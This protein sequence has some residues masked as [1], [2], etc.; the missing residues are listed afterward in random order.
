[1]AEIRINFKDLPN[2]G[3][4]EKDFVETTKIFSEAMKFSNIKL[5]KYTKSNIIFPQRFTQEERENVCKNQ[6]FYKTL[7]G[8]NVE[9]DE[10]EEK[11]IISIPITFQL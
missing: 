1:M 10:N 2:S 6:D 11:E 9:N 7:Y 3:D 8:E 5:V 4:K